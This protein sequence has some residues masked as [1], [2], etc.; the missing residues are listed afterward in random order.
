M[1]QKEAAV[2]AHRWIATGKAVRKCSYKIILRICSLCK[3]AW[4]L[5][6]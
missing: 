2:H 5:P 6:T 4:S 1:D 3:Q